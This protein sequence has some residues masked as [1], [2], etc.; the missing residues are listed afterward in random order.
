[1]V[2]PSDQNTKR[3]SARIRHLSSAYRLP[4]AII[5]DALKQVTAWG[6]PDPWGEV[7]DRLVEDEIIDLQY[8]M[9]D[10]YATGWHHACSVIAAVDEQWTAVT[11]EMADEDLPSSYGD[12]QDY[13]AVEV[14]RLRVARLL[15]CLAGN[16]DPGMRIELWLWQWRGRRDCCKCACDLSWHDGS[17]TSTALARLLFDLA[18][19]KAVRQYIATKQRMHDAD[20]RICLMDPVMR[21]LIGGA[22]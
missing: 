6:S 7:D 20:H 2:M 16:P 22:S 5:K 19:I 3:D 10:E 9:P 11:D 1:M 14:D 17:M 21:R 12:M 18:S 13:A 15:K 8:P 4:P